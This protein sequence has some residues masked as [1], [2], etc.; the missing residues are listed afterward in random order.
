[1]YS[2]NYASTFAPPLLYSS[3]WQALRQQQQHQQH[4]HRQRHPPKEQQRPLKRHMHWS[5]KCLIGGSLFYL[6]LIWYSNTILRHEPKPQESPEMSSSLWYYRDWDTLTTEV[7]LWWHSFE[8]P[9]HDTSKNYS[10]DNQ[11]NNETRIR[12]MVQRAFWLYQHKDVPRQESQ[13][14]SAQKR[15]RLEQISYIQQHI[16]WSGNSTTQQSKSLEPSC[17]LLLHGLPRSLERRVLPTWLRFVL[18]PNLLQYQ[19]HVVAYTD[20]KTHEAPGRSGWGGPLDPTAVARLLPLAVQL[21]WQEICRHRALLSATSTSMRQSSSL[22]PPLVV[23]DQYTDEEVQQAHAE[24][25]HD[26]RTVRDNST[27][28]SQTNNKRLP[29]LWYVPQG[30][31]QTAADNIVTMWHAIQGVYE[32]AQSTARKHDLAFVRMGVFR[33]D[34]V[35]TTPI[36]IFRYPTSVDHKSHYAWDVDNGVAVLPGFAQNP[37]NDRLFYGPTDPAVHI[38]ATQRF[39]TIRSFVLSR[40]GQGVGM[41]PETFVHESL[42]PQMTNPQPQEQPH[43]KHAP[44]KPIQVVTDPDLCFVRVR[45]DA[46]VWV[47]DCDIQA[48]PNRTGSTIGHVLQTLQQTLGYAC[49]ITGPIAQYKQMRAPKFVVQAQCRDGNSI[50]NDTNHTTILTKTRNR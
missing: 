17:V 18:I 37:V 25:W 34:V 48:P 16:L 49:G 41:H 43:S 31:T 45:A 9:N 4:R 22:S 44:T 1:M 28:L 7:A 11:D 46:S 33:A 15:Q 8:H 40:P 6:L 30:F 20:A 23:V 10:T 38:Y 42:L 2:S 14:S 3:Q 5:H 21:T 29:P 50:P 35:Y 32:L 27:S 19:C 12:K 47:N 24:L 13:E 39:P 26:I 36:D